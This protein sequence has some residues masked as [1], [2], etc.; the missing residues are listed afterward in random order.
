MSGELLTALT[1]SLISTVAL[2]AGFF[3]LAGKR[4]KK[5]LLLTVMVN[6]ITNPA[7][8]LLYWLAVLYTGWNRIVIKIPLELFAVFTE[9]YYYRKYGRD[10]KHPYLFSIATNAFSFGIGLLIQNFI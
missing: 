4:N 2:E 8:V 5:D 3:L 1:V 6:I 9:G 10:F 7:V